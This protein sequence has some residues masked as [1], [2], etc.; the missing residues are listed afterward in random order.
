MCKKYWKWTVSCNALFLMLLLVDFC[1]V[2]LYRTKNTDNLVKKQEVR[3][4]YYIVEALPTA[5]SHPRIMDENTLVRKKQYGLTETEYDLL[6]RLVEA[7]AGGEDLTGKLLVANV[8]FNR[9]KNEKFPNSVSEVILQRDENGAQFSPVSDGRIEA[10]SISDQTKEAVEAAV[11]GEDISGGAL[12]F[13]AREA[14][15]ADK[16]KWFDTCL[17]PVLCHGGHEFFR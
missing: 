7:E 6:L 10:V 17:T 4:V 11:Y 14:A 1:H 13:V 15:D 12:Y 9:L 8:V 16:L 3:G 2:G 5:I